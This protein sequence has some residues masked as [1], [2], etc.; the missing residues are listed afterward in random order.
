MKQALIN[1]V[2]PF[3]LY[4]FG[5]GFAYRLINDDQ[6]ADIWLQDDDAAV[7]RVELDTMASI[8]PDRLYR[9]ILG[10]LW[11]QY[12]ELARPIEPEGV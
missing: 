11:S 6:N 3:R 4:S 1:D 7:F 5:M 10:E 9:D 2:A 8:A 12:S